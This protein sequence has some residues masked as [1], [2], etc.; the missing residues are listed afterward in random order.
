LWLFK[1]RSIEIWGL[2]GQASENAF[3][4]LGGG[5]IERGLL[6]HNLIAKAPNAGFFVGDDGIC[7]ITN[8]ADIAPVSR[9]PIERAI[10]E[11]TPTN[12]FYYEDEG[13]KFCVVRFA[14]RPSW[15]YDLSTGM[16][17]ERATLLGAWSAMV[18]ARAFGAWRAGGEDGRVVTLARTNADNGDPL[19]REATSRTLEAGGG[20]FIVRGVEFLGRVGRSDIGRDARMVVQFSRDGGNTWGAERERS[21][22][23]LGEYATRMVFR[24][25]GQQRRLTARIR[26]SDPA[27]LQVWSAANVAVQ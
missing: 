19:I 16:W 11:E 13:H 2:T 25:V 5:V 10:A 24:N 15:V 9:T 23:D 27:D 8:G 7:Y 3:A 6:G 22:G 20:R 26:V 1:R 4:R 18:T 14:R 17:H 12:C 21:M